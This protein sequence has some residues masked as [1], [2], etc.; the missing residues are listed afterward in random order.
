MNQAAAARLS[1]EASSHSVTN[2]Q[3]SASADPWPHEGIDMN[4]VRHRVI[5]AYSLSSEYC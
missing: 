5:T 1:Q 4:N 3:T 2:F